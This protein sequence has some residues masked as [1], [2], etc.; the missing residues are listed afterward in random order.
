M[1][2]GPQ[3]PGPGLSLKYADRAARLPFTFGEAR[4]R[5]DASIAARRGRPNSPRH[6]RE[7][8]FQFLRR[9]FSSFRAALYRRGLPAE[10][11]RRPVMATGGGVTAGGSL[12]T[13]RGVARKILVRLMCEFRLIYLMERRV[14]WCDWSVEV[15]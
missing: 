4:A 2:D 6:S 12:G 7:M 5:V 9:I 1:A 11:F 3:L 10:L 14:I 13:E 8:D 15:W